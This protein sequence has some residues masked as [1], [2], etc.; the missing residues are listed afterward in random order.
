[1]PLRLDVGLKKRRVEAEIGARVAHL[2]Q[3]GEEEYSLILKR[4]AL[5]F[6]NKNL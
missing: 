3:L 2:Y 6:L 5:K 4:D 1:M